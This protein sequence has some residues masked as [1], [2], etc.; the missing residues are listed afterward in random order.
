MSTLKV[1]VFSLGTLRHRF[2]MGTSMFLV[3]TGLIFA[4]DASINLDSSWIVKTGDNPFWSD[5]V[6]DD[7][8][9]QSIKV[10]IPWENAGLPGYDGYAWYRLSFVVPQDWQARDEHGFLSLSLGQID[11][12][13]IT[14]FN[15]EQIGAAG[16]M[17]PEYETGYYTERYYR[18]PTDIVRWGEPNVLAVRVY[19]GGNQG[20]LT[21][22]PYALS[23]PGIQDFIDITF[24]LEDAGGLYFSP[25]PLP[26][27]IRIQNFSTTPF[28]LNAVFELRNDRIDSTRIL[29]S[30]KEAFVVN[31]QDHAI[32]SLTFAPPE[33][34]FYYVTCTL[35]DSYTKSM[36]FG[37]D[38]EKIVTPITREPDFEQFWQDRK[39][40]LAAVEPNFKVTK[41]DRSN[42]KLDVYLVD[43]QSYGNVTIRG[44]YTVPTSSGPHPAILSLPG[45]TSTM[46][47]YMDRTNVATLALNPRGHGNSKD[48]VDP[49]GEELMFLGFDPQHPKDYIYAGVY[50]DCLRAIDFLVSRPEIETSR[51]GVEGGSQ[52]GGLS[53]ATAAL[54]SRVIFS[55]PD[56]PWL[57]DWVG[58]FQTE[59]WGRE[60]Y[61]KLF[62]EY[63]SL[64]FDDINRFLSYFDTMNMAEWITCPVLMSVGLQ[65]KVCPPRTSFAPFN[66]V[67]SPKEYRVYPFAGH[68]TW[69]Q[70]K[71]FKNA[72]MAKKL[73]IDN[74]GEN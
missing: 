27:T 70:H 15:G 43:M 14:Y 63:P 2:L 64:T 32:K 41:T 52:G 11:D 31:A 71:D 3:F 48:D 42:D 6:F 59:Y 4:D 46:W 23:L 13:D 36:L 62:V 57:G 24:K 5:P 19:D 53:F 34:G 66:A 45:Y 35:N 37:Y 10:G 61:P 47:P 50:M 56:I 9:W 74:L 26:A 69:Q 21:R 1:H 20:G 58:Y 40:E 17:P 65:D 67:T 49:S 54:D 68:G 51:I 60:N 22:G 38:P 7:S 25:D 72:W 28:T 44:W 18:V 12:A 55:A 8:D 16:S 73:G 30:V 29:H 39:T 33:P